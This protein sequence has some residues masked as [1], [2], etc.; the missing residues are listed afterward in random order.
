VHTSTALLPGSAD[1]ISMQ[2]LLHIAVAYNQYRHM[3]ALGSEYECLDKI[4][5]RNNTTEAVI[6]IIINVDNEEWFEG[7]TTSY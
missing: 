2:L 7:C 4:D 3:L 6:L 5:T 1:T